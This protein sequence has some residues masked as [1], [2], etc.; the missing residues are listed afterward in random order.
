MH[1]VFDY[2]CAHM[3]LVYCVSVDCND[4]DLF[5]WYVLCPVPVWCK[6]WWQCNLVCVYV[7]MYVYMQW[8]WCS[9]PGVKQPECAIHP[10]PM[11]P[12]SACVSCMG[13]LFIMGHVFWIILYVLKIYCVRDHEVERREVTDLGKSC[14]QRVRYEISVS[15]L[16]VSKSKGCMTNKQDR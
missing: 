12:F 9:F 10:S 4:W 1:E 3:K 2:I 15:F 6:D 13:W 7:C 8:Y 5:L 16:Y 11:H 14:P